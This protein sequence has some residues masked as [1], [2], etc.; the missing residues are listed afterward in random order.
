MRELR[1][2]RRARELARGEAVEGRGPVRRQRIAV[3]LVGVAGE[4]RRRLEL[5]LEAVQHAGEHPGEHQ[6]RI[7]VR[8][9]EPVLEAQV[10]G[11]GGR[12]ANRRAAI[13]DR[14][15]GMQRHVGF[16]AEAAVGI[17]AR[18]AHRHAVGERRRACPPITWRS[19]ALSSGFAAAKMLRPAASSRLT[20]MCR[21]L[22]AMSR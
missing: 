8:A 20:C 18:R 14:P 22:P 11:V 6:V 13:V 16:G 2:E 19:G 7:R 21:P 3:L 10:V 15:V 4:H 17:R 9:G 1:A 5:V 12:H